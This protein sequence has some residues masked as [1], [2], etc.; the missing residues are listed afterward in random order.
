MHEA[1]KCYGDMKWLKKR[2]PKEVREV[3]ARVVKILLGVRKWLN[4]FADCLQRNMNRFSLRRQKI[5]LALFCLAF[6]GASFCIVLASFRQR[7]FSYRPQPI[8]VMPLLKER[9]VPASLPFQELSRIHRFK[10]H[11][12]SLTTDERRQFFASRPH[13]MDTINFLESLYQKEINKK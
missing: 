11:I 5:V 9:E 7:S 10:V 4:S 6:A 12:D 2:Y 8:S 3:D 1:S 13:L